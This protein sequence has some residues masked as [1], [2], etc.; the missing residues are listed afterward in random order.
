MS[1]KDL[2]LIF[3]ILTDYKFTYCISTFFLSAKEAEENEIFQKGKSVKMLLVIIVQICEL[4]FIKVLVYFTLKDVALRN[5]FNEQLIQKNR[6][7]YH[8]K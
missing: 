5:I 7:L 8:Q 2:P 6:F 3:I 1:A 4:L